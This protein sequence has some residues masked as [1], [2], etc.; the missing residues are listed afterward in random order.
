MHP[1][2][3]AISRDEHRALRGEP[4]ARR[5]R[6]G[7]QPPALD[8]DRFMDGLGGRGR[9]TASPG[10]RRSQSVHGGLAVPGAGSYH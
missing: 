2:D 5:G 3:P 10:A 6:H 9:G 4:R 1:M 8:A 7:P